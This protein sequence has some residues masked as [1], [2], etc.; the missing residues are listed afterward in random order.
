MVTQEAEI[1]ST[2]DATANTG[3][4]SLTWSIGGSGTYS[5]MLEPAHVIGKENGQWIRDSPAH[6]KCPKS[7]ERLTLWN[8]LH[9]RLRDTNVVP[10]HMWRI[11]EWNMDQLMAD[12]N[13]PVAPMK[14]IGFDVPH[15]SMVLTYGPHVNTA[16]KHVVQATG[17]NKIDFILRRVGL[18]TS[19]VIYGDEVMYSDGEEE[20]FEGCSSKSG[21]IGLDEEGYFGDESAGGTD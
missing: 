15:G 13:Q 6:F 7:L 11:W 19:E 3:D 8:D 5:I 21:P 12:V 10:D 18:S 4:A 2:F 17:P 1:P 16:Y 14:I 9:D 20:R